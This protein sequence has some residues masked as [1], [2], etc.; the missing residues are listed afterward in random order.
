[1]EKEELL[2]YEQR[3]KEEAKE[4][5]D[6]SIDISSQRWEEYGGIWKNVRSTK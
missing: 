2:D 1:M 6:K 4:L 3:E 5:L